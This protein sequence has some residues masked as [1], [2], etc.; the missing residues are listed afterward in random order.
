MTLNISSFEAMLRFEV[1]LKDKREGWY[2][3]N[4][5]LCEV[6]CRQIG[7]EEKLTGRLQITY[8]ASADASYWL[9]IMLTWIPIQIYA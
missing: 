4:I 6:V 5:K 3:H 9:G 2:L 8:R 7:Q 1:T